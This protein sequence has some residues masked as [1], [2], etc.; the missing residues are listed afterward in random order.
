[1]MA[2]SVI[3]WTEFPAA[4]TEFPGPIPGAT[5][6]LNSSASGTGPT[7]PGRDK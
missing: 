3:Y 4:N 2:T 6:F 5:D 7:Q 1:M